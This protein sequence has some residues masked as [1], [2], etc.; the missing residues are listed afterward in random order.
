MQHAGDHARAQRKVV[1]ESLF[2]FMIW[3]RLSRMPVSFMMAVTYP[4]RGTPE[5]IK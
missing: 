1:L 3:Y 4:R 2:A 5:S